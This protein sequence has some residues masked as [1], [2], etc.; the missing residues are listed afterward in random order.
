MFCH[1]HASVSILPSPALKGTVLNRQSGVLVAKKKKKMNFLSRPRDKTLGLGLMVRRK[2]K[3]SART[4]EMK[5]I[6][7][8]QD[9]INTFYFIN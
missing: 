3:M 7:K 8:R 2:T 4:L 6:R 5:G 1:V 9:A